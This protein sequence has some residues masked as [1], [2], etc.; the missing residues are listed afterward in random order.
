MFLCENSFIK[1]FVTNH[2]LAD[3]GIESTL[4]R[5]FAISSNISYTEHNHGIIYATQTLKL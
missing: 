5:K 4:R 2:M 3:L 1:S